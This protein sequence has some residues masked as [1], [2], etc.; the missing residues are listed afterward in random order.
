MSF[1]F[2]LLCFLIF[3]SEIDDFYMTFSLYSGFIGGIVISQQ[4]SS[5]SSL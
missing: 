5:K 1:D 3:R 4:T 2:L